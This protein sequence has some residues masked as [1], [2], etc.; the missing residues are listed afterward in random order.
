[1]LGPPRITMNRPL[2]DPTGQETFFPVEEELDFLILEDD[3]HF[4]LFRFRR[5]SIALTEA[6]KTSILDSAVLPILEHI[7]AP[8]RKS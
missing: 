4:Y 5:L 3:A 1:M 6:T 2:S 8:G 7:Y